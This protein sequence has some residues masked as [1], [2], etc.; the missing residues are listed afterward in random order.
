MSLF[1]SLLATF[2]WTAACWDILYRKIPNLIPIL[3]FATGALYLGITGQVEQALSAMATSLLVLG[4]GVLIW[5]RGWLGAG[6]VK[7]LAALSLWAGPDL[8]L[9][10]LL[11]TALVGGLLALMQLWYRSYSYM[12]L[13]PL[14]CWLSMKL[15]IL[16]AAPTGSRHSET[17]RAGGPTDAPTLPY[18][19]AVAAGGSWV[20]Y[21]LFFL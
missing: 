12:I 6:D 18:G 3:T 13:L 11:V 17:G 21:N 7:L 16:L 2:L 14:V 1:L 5:M 19:V 10:M 8:V 9:P 20:A 4:I 15:G